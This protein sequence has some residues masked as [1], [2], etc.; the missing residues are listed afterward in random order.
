MSQQAEREPYGGIFYR[1]FQVGY[2]AD[3][4]WLPVVMHFFW[5]VPVSMLSLVA[6]VQ[7]IA[8]RVLSM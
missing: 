5:S 8:E 4:V 3:P 7:L 6:R 1:D 2:R